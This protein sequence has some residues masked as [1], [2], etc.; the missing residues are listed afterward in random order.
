ME[1]FFLAKGYRDMKADAPVPA[2][3]GGT[4]VEAGATVLDCLGMELFG[5]LD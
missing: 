2:V 1:D 4:G 3:E 5:A